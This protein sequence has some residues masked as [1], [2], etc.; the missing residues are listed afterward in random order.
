MRLADL[1]KKHDASDKAMNSL[2][3]ELEL[4]ISMDLAA[5]PIAPDGGGMNGHD[6]VAIPD[7]PAAEAHDVD[8][9]GGQD[10]AEDAAQR[11][12]AYTQ[13]RLAAL[14]AFQELQLDA[15]DDLKAVTAALA[16]LGA[17]TSQA[18]EFISTTHAS[19]HRANE[20]E[21]GNAALLSENRRLQQQVEQIKRLRSQ[22]ET[23]AETYRRKEARHEEEINALKVDISSTRL[24][25]EEA[26]NA[27]AT[28]E[29]ERAN[30]LAELSSKSSL[31]E[32]HAHENELLREKQVA[33]SHEVEHAERRATEMERKVDEL[34]A[35]KTAQS[36][37]ITDLRTR[38]AASEKE[39]FQLQKL[40]D[41]TSARLAEA[42]DGASTLEA[43][44]DDVRKRHSA[45]TQRLKGEIETL[46][47]RAEVSAKAQM[48]A[49]DE[50]GT[51]KQKLAMSE[52]ERH[53]TEERLEVMRAELEEERAQHARIT[54]QASESGLNSESAAIMLEAR[55]NEI[56]ELRR[57][58]KAQKDEIRR[59]TSIERLYN[60]L[61]QRNSAASRK[62][63][64]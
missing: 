10:G 15:A 21:V 43:A 54:A 34:T 25:L 40:L 63:A 62:A 60:Q 1:F 22:H 26:Q 38:L 2:E 47:A 5:P 64:E 53:Q 55:A 30:L 24:E 29:A 41:T 39:V 16:R 11:L 20:L 7:R 4:M 46:K 8:G 17:A 6:V 59:L 42:Q 35:I 27:L 56:E 13:S 61:K 12:T 31:G 14:S 33:L 51:L 37:Q 3:S 44:L 28:V 23:L 45:E 57:D 49:S 32:R 48:H 18:R 58:L 50:I 19:I 52:S 9:H 36:G